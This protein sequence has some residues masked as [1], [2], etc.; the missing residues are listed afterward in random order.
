MNK[1][2]SIV[3]LLLVGC[4]LQRVTSQDPTPTS[5]TPTTV[6]TAPTTKAPFST[7]TTYG[8]MPVDLKAL[9]GYWY[10]VARSPDLD[11]SVCQNYTFPASP[12][13]DNKLEIQTEYVSTDD[14]KREPMKESGLLPWDSNSQ[15]GIF[16]WNI[17]ESV[18]MSVTYKLLDTDATSYALFCGYIG[19]APVPLFKVLTRKRELITEE[20]NK[21]QQK[22]NTFVDKQ[23]I[24]I[25]Q[26]DEKCNSAMR[27]AG[28]FIVALAL[29]LLIRQRNH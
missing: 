5:A 2:M 15:H 29:V 9:S 11:E 3:L 18:Q 17:G 10:E 26:S 8:G 16:N 25:E 14:N 19:I 4:S 6:S 28:G 12:N 13:A 21:V 24:W 23:L 1:K 20:K 22:F 7:C 27:S